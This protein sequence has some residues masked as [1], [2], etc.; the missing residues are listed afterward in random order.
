MT[1]SRTQSIDWISQTLRSSGV[2][3]AATAK[4]DGGKT[5]NKVK[6]LITSTSNLN[7]IQRERLLQI[8]AKV[9]GMPLVGALKSDLLDSVSQ[10]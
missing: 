2:C 7:Y 4:G 6:T 10:Y 5:M 1:L 8:K 9:I 3:D